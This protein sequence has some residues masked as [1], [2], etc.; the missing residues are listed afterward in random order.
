M[1][2]T[3]SSEKKRR[4]VYG[5]VFL[6]IMSVYLLR[7]TASGLW[8]DEA[9]E[10]YFSSTLRGPVPGARSDYSMYRRILITYQPP[11]YNWLMYGWLQLGDSEF[12]FRLAGILVTFLGGAGLYLGLKEIM[13]QAWAAAGGAV[14]LLAGGVSRYALEAGEYN[15]AMCMICWTL[16]FYLLALKREKTGPLLG[17]FV[18]ACL[19]AYS[20]YGTVF[21]I[22]PMYL[23]LLI[24]FVKQRK[25]LGALFFFSLLAAAAAVPLVVYF[26]LPQMRLQGSDSVSHVPVFVNGVIDPLVSLA[27]TAA[28][29]FKDKTRLQFAAA[30]AAGA[31]ALT[32]L[33]GKNK[34]WFHIL[35]LF[36]CSWMSYYL[37]TACTIYGYNGTYNPDTVGTANIGGRYSLAFAPLLTAA[38]VYGVYCACTRKP[39]KEGALSGKKLTAAAL[40]LFIAYSAI[41]VGSILATQKKDDVREATQVWYAQEAYNS[42]TLVN[43]WDDPL[44]QF[45]LTHS[46]DYAEEYQQS[47]HRA[48]W[49]GDGNPEQIETTLSGLGLLDAE[50]FYYISKA[51]EDYEDHYHTFIQTVTGLG[52]AVEEPYHGAS[53]LIHA[54]KK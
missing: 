13:D 30:V 9:I 35:F 39:E 10:Y 50:D 51:S 6:G 19:A 54:V 45:Y 22:V 4:L 15:L 43:Q 27:K 24:H 7:A 3:L 23:S 33:R 38:L 31:L 29:T 2:H 28:F 46:P 52:F 12:W 16:C 20:Q 26:L 36:F 1:N 34:L 37:I 25:K 42:R 21:L 8:F 5:A 47:I 32:A 40:C 11:L 14:Y 44:F 48:P 41:G 53:A 49:W 18:F 17:F